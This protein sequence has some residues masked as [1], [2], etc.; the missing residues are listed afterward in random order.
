M[1]FMYVFAARPTTF[2]IRPKPLL[3]HQPTPLSPP[4]LSSNFF[5]YIFYDFFK[6]NYQNQIWQTYTINVV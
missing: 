2:Q 4:S 3:V 1:S 5:K 6:I